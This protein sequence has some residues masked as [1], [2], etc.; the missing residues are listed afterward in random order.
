M[1]NN[2]IKPAT[3]YFENYPPWIVFFSNL[4]SM[5]IYI[6]GSFIIYKI[7]FFYFTL[8]LIFILFLELRVIKGHCVDCYYYGK[9]CAFGKGKISGI[10]FKK[11][12]SNRFCGQQMNWL[13]ILPDFLVSLVPMAAGIII[14]INNFSWLILLLVIVL[15]ILAFPGSGM[16]RSQLAC[17]YCKQREIGCP[18]QKLFAKK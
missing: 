7:G 18:A 4:V 5:A 14:L 13:D 11:G 12:D 17:K 1:I 16:I 9:T 8:Y 15:F 6:I 10:F 3:D 2:E